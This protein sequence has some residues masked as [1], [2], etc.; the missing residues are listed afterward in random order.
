MWISGAEHDLT[1]NI[2]NLVLFIVPKYLVEAD[3]SVGERNDVAHAGLNHKIGQRGI[4]YM[5][6]M[7]NEARLGVG[8]GAVAPGHTGYLSHCGT[9]VNA[10]RARR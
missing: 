8:M 9:R 4:T 2:V 7:M 6:R 10:G 1:E 3:G 5:F